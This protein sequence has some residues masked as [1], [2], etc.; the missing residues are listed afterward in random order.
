[1]AFALYD[2]ILIDVSNLYYRAYFVAQP[3]MQIVDGKRMNTGG[4][5][6]A[7]KMI[8]RIEENYLAEGGRMYFLFDN[9][10]SGEEHRHDID[11]DYKANRNKRLPQFYRGLDYLQ[12]V[13]MHYKTGYR[14]VRRA[15]SEADDLVSP[16]LKSFEGKGLHVLLISNDMDWAREITNTTV[17]MT[18][19]NGKDVIYNKAVFE[20]K[21]GFVPSMGR[22]C[23]YKALLG[24]ESDNIAPGVNGITE[25]QVL[26]ILYKAGSV[27]DLYMNLNSLDIPPDMKENIRKSRGKVE[28]NERLIR[29]APLSMD[30]CRESTV[31]AEYNHDILLKLYKTLGFEPGEIDRRFMDNTPLTVDDFFNGFGE[32]PRA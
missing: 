5:L 3:A 10:F 32:I 6:A 9:A 1:M 31:I 4:I 29:Y 2:R 28:I 19:E 24:D 22:V 21:Y 23:L 7:L 14:V 27:H 18:R 11:P 16:I 25:Q 17:W 30:E 26:N 20:Q 8:G 12:L 15:D 13:M